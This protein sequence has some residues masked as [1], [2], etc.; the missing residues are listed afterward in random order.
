M[1]I[2]EAASAFTDAIIEAASRSIPQRTSKPAKFDKPWV[3]RELKKEIGNYEI[4]LEGEDKLVKFEKNEY[5]KH[6]ENIDKLRLKN[7]NKKKDM[8]S[9]SD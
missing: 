6:R 5:R 2:D 7:K 3:T 1:N 9:D 4:L 8:L